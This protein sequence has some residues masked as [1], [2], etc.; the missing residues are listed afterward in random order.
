MSDEGHMTGH[1]REAKG[2]LNQANRKLIHTAAAAN[3]REQK[4]VPANA[5]WTIRKRQWR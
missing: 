5:L 4:S 3:H 2:L 1:A